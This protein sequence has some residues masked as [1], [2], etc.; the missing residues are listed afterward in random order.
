MR[1][2]QSSGARISVG[3][4]VAISSPPAKVSKPTTGRTKRNSGVWITRVS[5]SR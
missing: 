3:P 1:I 5:S 4:S 2:V